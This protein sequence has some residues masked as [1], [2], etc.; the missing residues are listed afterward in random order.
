MAS[1]KDYVGWH[2]DD[3]KLYGPTPEIASVSFGR[4]HE[5]LLKNKPWW[6]FL[7]LWIVLDGAE[8]SRHV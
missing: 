3:E 4:E 8:V 7:F 6:L 1:G 5:F 2:G